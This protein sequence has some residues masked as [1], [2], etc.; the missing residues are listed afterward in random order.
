MPVKIAGMPIPEPSLVT[1]FGT[2]MTSYDPRSASE[3]AKMRHIQNG[4]GETNF[5]MSLLGMLPAETL[6]M[7]LEFVMQQEDHHCHEERQP[8][9]SR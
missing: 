4:F 1:D 7:V 6:N 2:L 5:K 9:N 3:M 8:S